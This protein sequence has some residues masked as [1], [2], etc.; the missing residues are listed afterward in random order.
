MY[1]LL[2]QL[3]FTLSAHQAHEISMQLLKV[4][5]SVSLI[6]TLLAQQFSIDNKALEKNVF[7]LTFK[8]P[9]GLAAGFDKNAE[10]LHE[11]E[12]LG[13]GF[14]EIGTVTP[15]AQPGNPRPSLFRL[16]KDLALINR[17]GFNNEGVMAAKKRLEVWRTN[18]TNSKLI[19]GSNIG[20]NKTTEHEHAHED[21]KTCFNELYD[22][23]DYFV[24]NVSSP[25][26]PGLRALQSK[27]ALTRILGELI[28]ENAGKPK[29]KP[30]LLK[31]A[32]DL[33]NDELD[34][35][36]ALTKEL[37][38]SG[39]VSSNTT[40]SREN[41]CTSAKTIATIGNGGLSGKPLKTK[42]DT[43]IKY[44]HEKNSEMP[45]IASGGIFN[46]QDAKDKFELGAS[47]VQV[48][49]GFIYEG[50]SIAKNICKELL[51]DS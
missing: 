39:I 14:I 47:L 22:A 4:G 16:P 30:I 33:S 38:I 40:I 18:H 8:N 11:L 24:V 45:L 2:R 20:I 31:I 27:E 37:N 29:S 23:S 3:L 19:I 32:P 6:K 44:V 10:Y 21:Y 49:T 36:I 51:K 42:S 48:W 35:I 46:G 9:V 17:M 26:T 1:A 7:G 28:H 12:A 13:F 43:V 25:N 50:P 34:D 5:C 41:L 15:K